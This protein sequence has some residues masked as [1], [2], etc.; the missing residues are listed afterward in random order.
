MGWGGSIVSFVIIWWLCLFMVLPIRQRNVWEEPDKHAKGSDRGAP[1][2][3]AL[4]FKVRL[5]TMIA[6]PI[7]LLVFLGV[8]F[9]PRMLEG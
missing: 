4:W 3:P 1:I 2:D 9:G 5:T 6:V 8:T 7:F